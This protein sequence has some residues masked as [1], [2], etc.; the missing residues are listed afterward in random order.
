MG[1][2]AN[3]AKEVIEGTLFKRH[4]QKYVRLS[5]TLNTQ[6]VITYKGLRRHQITPERG[7]VYATGVIN[8]ISIQK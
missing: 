7:A 3:V 5:S 6:A 4:H 8:N 1:S 2:H